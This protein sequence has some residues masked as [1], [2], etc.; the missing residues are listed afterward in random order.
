ML[1][2]LGEETAASSIQE[3]VVRV[4]GEG[5]VRTRDLGG[6]SGTA[7]VGQAVAEAIAARS[8]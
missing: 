3:A 2:W 4:L 8:R 5:R 1:S 7:E 6:E